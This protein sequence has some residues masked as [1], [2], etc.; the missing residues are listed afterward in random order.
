MR[1]LPK[2]SGQLLLAAGLLM[3]CLVQR[4]AAESPDPAPLD[5]NRDVRPILSNAC[6]HCHGP[7]EESRE[8]D[9]RLDEQPSAMED[10][11]GYHAIVA[12]K[13]DDSEVYLRLITEEEDERMPPAESGKK[14]TPEQIEILKRWIAEGATYA[15]HWSLTAPTRPESPATKTPGWKQNPIDGF[16]LQQLEASGMEPAAEADRRTLIRRAS[17][18]LR[19]LPPSIAEVEEFLSDTSPGAYEALIDRMLASPHFGE[20]M[21]VL[22]MDLARYGDTN[23]YHYDSTRQAWMWRDWVIN[24]YN[25]N[26]SFDQFTIEQLGG[27]LIADASVAQQIASG[28]NRNT[29]YNEEGGADPAEF[30][31]RYAVDRTNTLGQVWLGLTLGCCECHSHKYDPISHKEYYQLY[32]FFNSLDEPGAQ[33]HNQKYEPILRVPRPEQEQ[34]IADAEAEI[35]KLD[36]Q[37]KAEL[38]KISYEEPQPQ[39]TLLD[40]AVETVWFDDAFPGGAKLEGAEPQWVEKSAGPVATGDRALKRTA[41]GLQQ[42]FFINTWQ[43]LQI[44]TDDRLFV[45]V[46]LDPEN[47][48]EEIMVQFNSRGNEAGWRHRAYWGAN[49]IQFGKDDSTQRRRLGDLP[50]A[51]GWTRLEIPASAVGLEPGMNVYGLAFTQFGGTVTWDAAGIISGVAQGYRDKV[52]IDDDAPSG[53]KLNGNGQDPNWHWV[54]GDDH[55]VHSGLRSLRRSAK[56]RTQHYFEGADPPLSLKEG[57]FLFAHVYLDPADPP[58]A[59]QLQFNNGDWGHRISWG[60]PNVALG[61]DQEG[62]R[63]YHAGSLPETGK[64]VRLQVELD[65]VGLKAG[66]KISG[67]AFTQVDGTVYYDTAGVRRWGDTPTGNLEFS[68]LA[69]ER[70]SRDEK[71]LP[72]EVKDALKV[73][74]EDRVT[75]QATAVRDHYLRNIH[76]PSRMVFDPL[77]QQLGE[78]RNTV[79]KVNDAIPFQLV[80][81][82]LKEPRPAHVLLRGNFQTLGEKVEREVPA[83][84]PPMSKDQP[85][86]RLGL[87]YWLV[88]P[89]N[90][91]VSRV[92]VNR[93][94]AQMFGEGLVRTIGDFGSQ[95]TY[96]THRE[97]LD[98]LS[99]EFVESGWDVKHVLKTIAMSATYRQASIIERNYRE[100]DPNNLLLWKAPRVRLAAEGIRDNALAI[101]GLLS[102]KIGGPSVRPYQPDGYYVGKAPGGLNSQWPWE[103]SD[104]DAQYRRGMYTFWRRTTP[105]PTFM[106]FDATDR[107]NC[108]VSRPRTNSPLQALAGLNDPQFVEAARV[109]AQRVLV[110]VTSDLDAQLIHA[111]ELA[112]ARK[113]IDEELN[114]LRDAYQSQLKRYT[115]D[116]EAAEKL[117]SAGQYERP[118]NLDVVQHAAWTALC[119]AILNLDEVITRE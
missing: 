26:M 35:A 3:G 75:N 27:D 34:Q 61:A 5:F 91:T 53:A 28:F 114:I 54:G 78:L 7:E 48:P 43:Y 83:V 101:S 89:E 103:N 15:Q 6:F 20:R 44:G 19:G 66:D 25:D 116:P 98:W 84:L 86:N 11:G 18:D 76:G 58:T 118:E 51:G 24:A 99:V 87:A 17:L 23:G 107:A 22:W 9:L 92:Q 8:A 97:L 113:P 33:G 12:G 65:K 79:K 29:R 95:G 38:E 68:Q 106:I 13:P 74:P 119:N 73:E 105:Y 46:Y 56:G 42:I 112:T 62:P 2:R 41:D 59:I 31:V 94:W 4:S 55:P 77:N 49:K 1:R 82:E 110:E 117:A 45:S 90:P 72:K 111:F 21:A 109:M 14:I 85:R 67:W 100:Q 88:D 32:A 115:A 108:T 40:S 36:A 64:W 104:G 70:K 50:A 30:R 47:M 69:W 37:V 52:W 93:F 10:R 60:Q 16:V 81:V 71:S 80:S 102:S 63:N 57:D 96:P 39:L